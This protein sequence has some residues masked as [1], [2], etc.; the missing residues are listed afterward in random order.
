MLA[1]TFSAALTVNLVER[2]GSNELVKRAQLSDG[3]HGLQGGKINKSLSWMS[4]GILLVGEAL[5]RPQQNLQDRHLDSPRQR[6]EFWTPAVADGTTQ[7]FKWRFYLSSQTKTTKNFFHLMQVL[8]RGDG[9]ED[10]EPV[11]TLDAVNDRIMIKDYVRDCDVTGCPSIPWTALP[12]A[13][14]STSLPSPLVRRGASSMSSRT[15][16]D[17]SVALLSYSVKGAMGSD[18]SSIKFGTYRL[19]VDG[20][21]E[22]LAYAGDFVDE[23]DS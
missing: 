19:A 12:T 2:H 22:S 4:S 6:I 13:L 15:P 5:W 7:K 9:S 14:R 3:T 11:V 16:Q 1:V 8:S 21:T 20:M 23:S 18:S 10:A 17:E